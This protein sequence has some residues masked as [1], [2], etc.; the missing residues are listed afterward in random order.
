MLVPPNIN[1]P[2]VAEDPIIW[3]VEGQWKIYRDA[4]MLNERERTDQ[5][6]TEERRGLT[7]SLNTIL[8]I[9]RLFQL[10]K[11]ERMARDSGTYREEIVGKFYSSY[12][13]TPRGS[14]DKR[15]NLEA[16]DPLTSL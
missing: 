8:G 16:Q 11:C 9:Y 10:H 3:C 7:G 4:K 6:I 12:A 13:T 14:I 1:S 2:L 15:S 5:L